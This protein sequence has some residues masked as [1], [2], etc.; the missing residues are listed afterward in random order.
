[1][2]ARACNGLVK[3]PPG[4]EA[5]ADDCRPDQGDS[6]RPRLRSPVIPSRRRTWSKR[7][8]IGHGGRVNT[9][10]PTPAAS[11]RAGFWGELCAGTHTEVRRSRTGGSVRVYSASLCPDRPAMQPHWPCLP[12]MATTMHRSL[13]NY[14]QNA[15]FDFRADCGIL[16]SAL[17]IAAQ[18]SSQ[19]HRRLKR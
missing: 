16:G 17:N 18:H 7:S 14:I 1:M 15:P 6:R 12:Q 5:G 13:C 4:S 19:A 3:S 9:R 11:H 2:S 8:S 10:S